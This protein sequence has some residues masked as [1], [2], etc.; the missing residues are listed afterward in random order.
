MTS[1]ALTERIG[2]RSVCFLQPLDVDAKQLCLYYG[3]ATIAPLEIKFKYFTLWIFQKGMLQLDSE[4]Y[5][6]IEFDWFRDS[7][8]W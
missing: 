4:I 8:Q 7:L 3:P 1:Y 2:Q 6:V 5:Y